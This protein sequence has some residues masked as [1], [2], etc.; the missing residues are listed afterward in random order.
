MSRESR[1][2]SVWMAWRDLRAQPAGFRLYVL[3]LAL[4]IGA[5]VA[6][7]SFRD[8]LA[9]AVDRQARSLLGADAA[10]RSR[11]PFPPDAV[12][13]A[14][15]LPLDIAPEATFRSMAFFPA[16]G[17]TRF[18][19]VR[20][21]GPGFPFYGELQ[22]DPPDAAAAFRRGDTAL[23]EENILI[24]AGARVGDMV[25]VGRREF[26][27]GG[28]LLKAPGETPAEAFLAPRV[29][30]PHASLDDTGLLAPGAVVSHRLYVKYRPGADPVTVTDDLAALGRDLKVD[31]ETA[32]DR[33]ARFMGSVDQLARYLG[34][35][36][37]MA[38]LLGSLGTAGAVHVYVRR[39]GQAAAYLR[40][41]GASAATCW[42][43]FALQ[44]LAMAAAGAVLGLLVSLCL[45]QVLPRLARDFLPFALEARLGWGPVLEGLGAGLGFTL[46]F[47]ALP[48]M[49]VRRVS[50]LRALTQS[51]DRRHERVGAWPRALVIAALGLAVAGYACAQARTVGQGLALAAGLGVALALLGLAARG[52]RA[53]ARRW[54]E[55]FAGG[56]I[57][58]GVANLY[59]PNNQTTLLVS[60][61]GAGAMLTA[62]LHLSERAML[63]RL[64]VYRSSD[65]PSLVLIDVQPDQRQGVEAMVRSAGCPVLHEVPI[66]TMR[67]ARLRGRDPYDW[68]HDTRA[69][70]PEWAL[71]RE[72]RSTYR[73]E[74]S[75]TEDL[76][77]GT[78][79]G[80]AA[81]GQE[82]IPISFEE[83]IARTLKVT[84]GDEVTWDVQ[85]LPVRTRIASLRKVD[86]QSMKPNFF[87]VFP[88]GV[89]EDAPQSMA[90]FTRVTDVRVSAQLQRAVAE[91]Y[92]N[93]SAVDIALVLASVNDILGRI[94]GVVRFLALFTLGAGLLV[95]TGAV[96]A[97]RLHRARELALLRTLGASRR[98]VRAVAL[99]EYAALGMLGATA[100]LLLALA[101]GEMIARYVLETTPVRDLPFLLVALVA[102]TGMSML[103]GA[104]ASR[105]A[106]RQP[107]LE[108][109]RSVDL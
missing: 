12:A 57:R 7:T 51:Y 19:Q 33:R 64:S 6:V 2:F 80:R 8:S 13:R 14:T 20:A 43:V 107:P 47:A 10:L 38:L 87:A 76:R 96:R 25:R 101:A 48:L 105:E 84:I 9:G 71:Q 17:A 45:L 86:W 95:L 97:S 39:R 5:M 30:I 102:I 90:V 91:R 109:L 104:L 37:F 50:P 106:V 75:A 62:T 46:A 3:S 78:W 22:T 63:N 98:H 85:G 61:V 56:A 92:P 99:A 81:P 21:I 32:A 60:I 36:G 15:A 77:A 55:R 89:L 73:G 24:Q 53:A 66:V 108:A 74:L 59:R 35:V 93:V 54:A 23:V 27:V 44:V 58:Q 18:V 70:L 28:R 79:E 40:C 72:Y 100:G 68:Q 42:N 4:G 83:G 41:V 94:A 52:L 103:L 1:R 69:E 31:V 88:L 49:G 26:R 16:Q 82:V 11:R 65:Q 29:Y 67:I 34:L